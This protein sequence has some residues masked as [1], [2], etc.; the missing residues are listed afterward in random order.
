[1]KK[2]LS[3]KNCP[4]TLSEGFD[5]YSRTALRRV[6]QGKK[7]HHV[8][9]YDSPASNSETD[10][11]FEENRKYMSISGVQKK[12]SVLLEKTKPLWTQSP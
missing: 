4:G 12:F 2:E 3:I 1:M 5:T 7:V 10:E 6:F 9:P 11:M 8:L